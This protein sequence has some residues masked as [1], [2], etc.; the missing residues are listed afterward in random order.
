MAEPK[1]A[2][3]LAV[4]LEAKITQTIRT[5]KHNVNFRAYLDVMQAAYKQATVITDLLKVA[6]KMAND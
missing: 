6:E 4:E 3:E 1:T 2:A 5:S